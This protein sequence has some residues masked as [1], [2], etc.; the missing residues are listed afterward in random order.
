[1]ARLFDLLPSRIPN[2]QSKVAITF[3]KAVGRAF[4]FFCQ[5]NPKQSLA[6]VRDCNPEKLP[7][8]TLNRLKGPDL[9]R[10]FLDDHHPQ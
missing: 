10:S 5:L 3:L 2:R 4:V 9:I 6:R 8:G 7:Q 1:M